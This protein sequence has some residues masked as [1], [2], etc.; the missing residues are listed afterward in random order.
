DAPDLV[1]ITVKAD[2]F[3]RA[4]R[5]AADY[6]RRGI[7]VVM[8]GLHPTACPEESL[9]TRHVMFIDYSV[10]QIWQAAS[11]LGHLVGMRNLARLGKRVAY[12][13]EP[14]RLS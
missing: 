10:S 13:G 14:A 1:G 12:G 2:T 6:R 3:L 5:L 9:G 8:G 7:P 4:A 11:V